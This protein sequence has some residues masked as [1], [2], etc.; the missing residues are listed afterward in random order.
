MAD[1][2][3]FMRDCIIPPSGEFKSV[4]KKKFW[5]GIV[6]PTLYAPR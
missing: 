5:E 4:Q 1:E 6:R 3:P 2:N